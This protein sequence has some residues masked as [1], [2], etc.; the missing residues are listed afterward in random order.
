ML[1]AGKRF[2]SL[3]RLALPGESGYS[4]TV[5]RTR[6]NQATRIR[7]SISVWFAP[8]DGHVVRRLLR[9]RG[10]VDV[11]SDRRSVWRFDRVVVS[12]L[13]CN[14][15]TWANHDLGTEMGVPNSIELPKV[16]LRFVSDGWT[17]AGRR[18]MPR[19]RLYTRLGCAKFT[20][21]DN[22]DRFQLTGAVRPSP[23]ALDDSA[24][25][26]VGANFP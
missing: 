8:D 22:H 21:V 15:R 9:C 1:G 25:P 3:L 12:R 17:N 24:M 7:Q 4:A 18:R 23:N 19:L 6:L 16:Q 5:R 2:L 13:D 20:V 14:W 26:N 11:Q 10:G